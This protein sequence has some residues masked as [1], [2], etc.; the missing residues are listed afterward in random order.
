MEWKQILQKYETYFNTISKKQ[1]MAHQV[2][3]KIL[4][5]S[6]QL[7]FTIDYMKYIENTTKNTIEN[8]TKNTTENKIEEN[9]FI[10]IPTSTKII[11]RK[12]RKK[13]I[14]EKK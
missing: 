14:S 1:I 11:K 8:T 3:H 6:F 2:A 10:P 9:D 12:R 7:E 13:K 5:S 4:G